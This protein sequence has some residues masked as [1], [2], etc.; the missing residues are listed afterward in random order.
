MNYKVRL[1]KSITNSI[2]TPSIKTED[3]C[4]NYFAAQDKIVKKATFGKRHLKL[5]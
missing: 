5:S 4:K 1:K 2:A 3:Y